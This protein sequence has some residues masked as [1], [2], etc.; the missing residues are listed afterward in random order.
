VKGIRWILLR[1]WVGIMLG[2]CCV[3]GG[4]PAA[5]AEP[6]PAAKTA[7]ADTAFDFGDDG[8]LSAEQAFAIASPELEGANLKIQW[9]IAP[10]HYLYKDKFLV[11][12]MET[13][14][15]TVGEP[16]LPNG[17][18]KQDEYYGQIEAIHD[19][20]EI[21]IPVQ[22]TEAGK[23][24][25]FLLELGWQGCA[26]NVLCYP[27]ELKA[28]RV[29]LPAPKAG[30]QPS[31]SWM[32]TDVP[33]AVVSASEKTEQ[34][35]SEQDQIAARLASGNTLLTLAGFLG[36]GLLLAFTP[37]VF[38]MIPILSGI[39]VG[40]KNLTPRKAFLLSLSYVLAMALTY[41]VAGVL[42]GLFGQN[43]QASFQNP[44]V[45]GTFSAI[46]VLLAMS[47]FGFYD[48]QMPSA[49][50]SRLNTLSNRQEGGNLIGVAIMGALSALIVGPCVAAPLAGALIYIGQ[51][52]DAVLGGLALFTLSI[53]MG[54]PLLLIGT[55]AG[56]WLPRAG[57]WMEA[58]KAVF[59]VMLLAVA[60]WM[61][62]RILPE[63][64][65]LLLWAALFVVSSLFLGALSQLPE[66]SN[67]WHKL[68]KGAGILLLLYG[69]LLVVGSATGSGGLW[70]PL[71]GLTLGQGASAAEN[72]VTF[73]TVKTLSELQQAVKAAKDQPV[74]VDFYADWCVVCREM[75][76]ETFPDAA[77]Q[78]QLRNAVLLK[79][80]V[81]NNSAEA[82][83]LLAS[84]RIPG[85]PAIL[86][87][88]KDGEEKRTFR[89]VG[90]MPAEAFAA[91]LDKALN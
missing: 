20:A 76:K 6:A 2:V 52:G 78:A 82:K 14:G 42:A 3:A 69:C 55:S 1:Y 15:I 22:R 51:T 26:E 41:T 80:D 62:E 90:F 44:W 37:C 66:H 87:F 18:V 67:G 70:Q 49:L 45:L 48:L 89:Q 32:E 27:A 29:T 8:S 58:I 63:S 19:L 81:T 5:W 36:F 77:V 47:M 84:F 17:V 65:S 68:W 83:A 21:R 50:Q 88:D 40:Q 25:S 7:P 23:A 39:I 75:E 38:P 28:Y 31:V 91:H 35:L 71:K 79:A 64:V 16:V 85:P 12:V 57:G 72:S 73:K 4:L 60:I 33:E 13:K 34:P 43:L 53:G 9:A 46:F 11:K 74:M 54:I 10:D 56:K 59:G 24:G 61:L 86:F 30:E